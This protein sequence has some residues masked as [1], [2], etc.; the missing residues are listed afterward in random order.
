MLS[1]NGGEFVIF[2]LNFNAVNLFKVCDGIFVL[3][4]GVSRDVRLEKPARGKVLLV[5]FNPCVEP[6]LH[7]GSFFET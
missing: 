5:G 2:S 1:E 6:I 3:A 4:D 7:R